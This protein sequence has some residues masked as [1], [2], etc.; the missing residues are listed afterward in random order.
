MCLVNT[1]AIIYFSKI[2]LPSNNNTL[3]YFV[4]SKDMDFTT[5]I[6][7]NNILHCLPSTTSRKTGYHP[8]TT[9]TRCLSTAIKY[10][11]ATSQKI[12]TTSLQQLVHLLMEVFCAH[13]TLSD[14]RR[15]K[16]ETG[17]LLC[18]P[19]PVL[20]T[21]I[22]QNE[23]QG[24]FLPNTTPLSLISSDRRLLCPPPCPSPRT[25]QQHKD[26]ILQ[27]EERHS[28][29]EWQGVGFLAFSEVE[30]V[31]LFSYFIFTVH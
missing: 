8:Q 5:V 9:W 3:L 6:T 14:V 4:P 13:H 25:T 11:T 18:L 16:Q 24:S 19:H 28:H 7:R 31:S 26:I 2:L 22:A 21:S 29:T 15:W 17:V 10:R 23:R 12:P 1:T 27:Y 20:M 30:C